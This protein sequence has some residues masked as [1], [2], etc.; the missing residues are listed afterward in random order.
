MDR[1]QEFSTSSGDS[2]RLNSRTHGAAAD[3]DAETVWNGGPTADASVRAASENGHAADTDGVR[4]N[5]SRVTS[6]CLPVCVEPRQGRSARRR[7]CAPGPSP[8]A[9]ASRSVS[10]ARTAGPGPDR[11]C[12]VGAERGTQSVGGFARS[13]RAGVAVTALALLAV[14]IAGVLAVAFPETARAQAPS[15]S[16]CDRTPEVRDKLVDVSPV[17]QCS[18]V[19]SGHLAGMTRLDLDDAGITRL[20]SGDFAVLTSL[21]SLDL[22]LNSITSLPADIFDDLAALTRLDLYNNNLQ[23]LPPNI[24]DNL[25]NLEIL[26]LPGNILHSLPPDVFKE[27]TGLDILDLQ[28]NNISRLDGDLFDSVTNLR[29]LLLSGNSLTTLPNGIL[30]SLTEMTNLDLAENNL[31]SLTASIFQNN[32][33]LAILELQTNNL[34]VLPHGIS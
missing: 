2:G 13:V 7:V 11:L 24:F 21:M 17:S 23:I 33:K 27:L 5:K 31:T 22:S 15:P 32:K 4:I 19:T 9:R 14:T 1:S 10:L 28:G 30:D 3:A 20:K 8:A 34:A 29:R 16:V 26:S 12:R 18:Q 25:E 6:A